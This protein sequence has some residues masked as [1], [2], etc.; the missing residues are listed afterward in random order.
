MHALPLA[1]ARSILVVRLD[2]LGDV[3]LTGPF[4][5]ELRRNAADP[6]GS[7]LQGATGLHWQQIA[8]LGAH[9]RFDAS[10]SP[11]AVS[12]VHRYGR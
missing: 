1:E 7:W 8:A 3:V 2:A 4:L 12:A 9:R 5:R 10:A 6:A 11:G